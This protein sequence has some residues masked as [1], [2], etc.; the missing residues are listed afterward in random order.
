MKQVLLQ[1]NICSCSEEGCT[2][3]TVKSVGAD[4]PLAIPLIATLQLIA[5]ESTGSLQLFRLIGSILQDTNVADLPKKENIN[6][7]S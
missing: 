4:A 2:A 5:N 3:T 1:I 7:L 6:Q